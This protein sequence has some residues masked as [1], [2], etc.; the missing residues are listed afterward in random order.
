MGHEEHEEHEREVHK[1]TPSTSEGSSLGVPE[2]PEPA[3]TREPDITA[4]GAPCANSENVLDIPHRGRTGYAETH[5]TRDSHDS[6]RTQSDEGGHDHQVATPHRS[7]SRAQSTTRSVR[8]VQKDAVRVPR[9]ERRGLFARLAVIAEVTEPYD[10]TRKK[11][12]MITVRTPTDEHS[13]SC[14]RRS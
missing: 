5:E 4:V 14:M 12:W 1:I 10:Y 13:P 9:G 11:K 8:S 2:R 6:E 3:Y 7:R